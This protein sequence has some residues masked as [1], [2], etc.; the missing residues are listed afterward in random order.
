MS[1]WVTSSLMT[2]AAVLAVSHCVEYGFEQITF[3]ESGVDA[4]KL[5]RNFIHSADR[6]VLEECVVEVLGAVLPSG[7]ERRIVAILGPVRRDVVLVLGE[8]RISFHHFGGGVFRK[9]KVSLCPPNFRS[10]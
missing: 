4:V 5:L 8:C 9:T 1:S 6:T 10:V 3:V 7:G 2:S